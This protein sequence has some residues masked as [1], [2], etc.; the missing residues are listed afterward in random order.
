MEQ[1]GGEDREWEEGL[2]TEKRNSSLSMDECLRLNSE[3]K[4]NKEN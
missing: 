2:Q 3:G 4:V 1:G